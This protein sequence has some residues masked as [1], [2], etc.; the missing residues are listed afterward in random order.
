MELNEFLESFKGKKRKT[1]ILKS[2]AGCQ[3][4]GIAL[5]QTADQAMKA[6]EDIG[7]EEGYKTSPVVAQRYLT[8]PFLIDGFKFDLRI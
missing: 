8:K 1:F 6:L 3:G 4:K 7:G 2:D 5:A